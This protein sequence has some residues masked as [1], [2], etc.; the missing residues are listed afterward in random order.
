MSA[1]ALRQDSGAPATAA[2]AMEVRDPEDGCLVG[3]VPQANC[4]DALAV[5][6]R[7]AIGRDPARDMPTHRR[8]TVLQRAADIVEQDAEAFARLIAR[9][10]IKTIREARREVARCV[11]TLRLCAE[12]ARRLTGETIAFDQAPGGVGR[13]GYFTREPVGVVLAITPFNDPLNLVAHKIGPAIAAGCAVILKPHERTPLSALRLAEALDT[14]GLPA[15]IL[16][17]ITGDGRELGPVLVKDNRV[18]LVSFTGGVEAGQRVAALVGLQRM[19]MELGGNCATI[20]LSDADLERAATCCAS[21]AFWAAGQNCLHVQRIIVE[22]G[23]YQPFR[24]TFRRLAESV[25]LGPKLHEETD[26][27]CLIDEA[28]A[29]RIEALLASA[30]TAG[31]RILTGGK[32]RGETGFEPTVV[33]NVPGDH[34]LSRDEVFGPVTVLSKA[35]GFDDAIAQANATEFGLQAAIFTRDLHHAH[36]AVRRLHVGTVLINDSSD[37]RIDAMPFG[38]VKRLG[39]GREGVRSAILAMTEAKV[40]CFTFA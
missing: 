5:L 12:E 1:T 13:G 32:R 31:A 27:G 11:H 4:A 18:R 28:A 25:R 33:E 19:E 8:M 35:S 14:A 9:E 38:G 2:R 15:G 7:A 21:G 36:E 10:L 3:T 6:D 22:G 34:P 17:V 29:E 30:L 24:D 37:F 40:A 26:M 16:Q 20:V 39:L 23:V